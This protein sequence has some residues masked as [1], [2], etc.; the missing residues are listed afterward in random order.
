MHDGVKEGD[1]LVGSI[2]KYAPDLKLH[3]FTL[4]CLNT[5]ENSGAFPDMCYK[6]SEL[7]TNT[8]PNSKNKIPEEYMEKV[9]FYTCLGNLMEAGLPLLRALRIMKDPTGFPPKE[10]YD[11]ISENIEG[12]ATFAEAVS[13]HGKYFTSFEVNMIKVGEVSGALEI[14]L[15][16]VAKYLKKDADILKYS[17]SPH[18]KSA[19]KR[20][21]YDISAAR[22][23]VMMWN[24][25]GTLLSSGVP[26]LQT[27]NLL[28]HSFPKYEKE[29]RAMHDG[30]KEGDSLV[31]S[32]ESNAPKANIHPFASAYLE[33]GEETGALPEM[34]VKLGELVSE[35]YTLNSK[36]YSKED[37]GKIQFYT[38]LAGM[39]DA[40]VPLLRCLHVI[41]KKGADYPAQS[42]LMGLAE[43]IESGSTFSE[44]LAQYPK[45]FTPFEVNMIKAGECCGALDVILK[46]TSD[47]LKKAAEVKYE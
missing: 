19:A 11:K 33:V 29:V 5:G 37:I 34:C 25:F 28:G 46:R 13:Q 30:V 38:R 1:S 18:E 20:S 15:D 44:S 12:G 45:V 8:S 3:P 42:V 17:A 41:Q 24:M 9:L 6:L 21:D 23:E 36:H 10:I 4:P 35:E 26:I 40:G 39:C 7:I 22:D 32:I 16:R 27:L 31:G 47:Y 14:V 43:A 2:E